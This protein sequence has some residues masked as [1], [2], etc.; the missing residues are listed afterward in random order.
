MKFQ[1][2]TDGGS[3]GNPGPSAFAFLIFDTSGQMVAAHKE[4]IG[5]T[6]NNV[7]EYRAIV[8]SLEEA[9]KRG[10]QEVES[11]MDSELACRQLQGKYKVNQPHL[12]VLVE[13]VR[14]LATSFKK[15]TYNHV[16]REN[17]KIQ[18]ADSLV[19]DAL[20]EAALRRR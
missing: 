2:Y 12:K 18:L 8:A 13:K 14:I 19:N 6:T 5:V 3:R 11:F 16:P 10:A 15:I 17:E 1:I 9:R 4:C 20:D 7:A